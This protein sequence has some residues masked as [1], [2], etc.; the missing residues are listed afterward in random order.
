MDIA[1]AMVRLSPRDRQLCLLLREHSIEEVSRRMGINRFSIHKRIRSIRQVFA[2]TE[3][4]K[5][6]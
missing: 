6:L 5:Y 1:K 4:H 2:K 3:I